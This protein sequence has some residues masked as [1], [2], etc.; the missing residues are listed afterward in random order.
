MFNYF[1]LILDSLS[2]KVLAI[3]V[4]F[5]KYRCRYWQYFQ[6]VLLTVLEI[7]LVIIIIV[8]PSTAS[9]AVLIRHYCRHC[10]YGLRKNFDLR[11]LSLEIF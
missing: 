6:K 9:A 3:I 10:A 2:V 11:R 8:T 7:I 5:I 4:F 1:E